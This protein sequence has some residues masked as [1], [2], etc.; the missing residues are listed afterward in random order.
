MDSDKEEY[1]ASSFDHSEHLLRLVGIKRS[2]L[3]SASTTYCKNGLTNSSCTNAFLQIIVWITEEGK[4]GGM[5]KLRKVRFSLH[6]RKPKHHSLGWSV[7]SFDVL[8]LAVYVIHNA[9]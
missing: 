7:D 4:D 8:A 2:A 6:T 3:Q 1:D 9:F 5:E